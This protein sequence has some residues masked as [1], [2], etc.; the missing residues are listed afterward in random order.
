MIPTLFVH[1]QGVK[2]EVVS[3]GLDISTRGPIFN[4]YD[5]IEGHSVF[6]TG[7]LDG[8]TQD[9]SDQL[10]QLAQ[11]EGTG[12]M[13]YAP[14]QNPGSAH[15][16]LTREGLAH[17]NELTK[18]HPPLYTVTG[19]CAPLHHTA[20]SI[21]TSHKPTESSASSKT[22]EKADDVTDKDKQASQEKIKK[23]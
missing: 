4:N 2:G 7:V 15:V 1:F 16:I 10:H 5:L 13:H 12:I 20:S 9:H 19:T 22:Q 8:L 18:A 14:T 23:K 11:T 3:Q 6:L 21:L 17:V